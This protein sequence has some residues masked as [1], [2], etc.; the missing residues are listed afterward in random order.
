MI[1]KIEGMRAVDGGP[2]QNSRLVE[3][4]VALLIELTRRYR[5]P[6]VSIRFEGI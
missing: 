5:V 2:L 3:A 1:E 4:T 6:G